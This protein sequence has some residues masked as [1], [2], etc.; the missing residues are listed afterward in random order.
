MNEQQYKFDNEHGA[1][2]PWEEK[3]FSLR[4]EKLQEHQRLFLFWKKGALAI[5]SIICVV[6]FFFAVNQQL[7]VQTAANIN[8]YDYTY[9]YISNAIFIIFVIVANICYWRKK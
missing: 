8:S 2:S 9:T 1:H 6:L 3:V 5:I 4:E 7:V